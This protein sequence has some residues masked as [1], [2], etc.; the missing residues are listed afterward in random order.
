MNDNVE[1]S[2]RERLIQLK[3]N[4]TELKLEALRRGYGLET[5][6]APAVD[7]LDAIVREVAEDVA[8]RRRDR[9]AGGD[10]VDETRWTGDRPTPS[11]A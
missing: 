11:R 9:A 7:D 1:T 2:A 5:A 3:R 4:L 10:P 8:H 6:A